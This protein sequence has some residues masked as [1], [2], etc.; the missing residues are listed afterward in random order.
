MICS[1]HRLTQALLA[2]PEG[3]CNP[4]VKTRTSNVKTRTSNIKTRTQ[5]A[6]ALAK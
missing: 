5:E 6:P 1:L 2:Y 4:N 3:L